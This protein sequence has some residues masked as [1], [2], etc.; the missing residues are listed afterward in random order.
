MCTL[1]VKFDVMYFKNDVAFINQEVRRQL[2]IRFAKQNATKYQGARL[3]V[4]ENC[5]T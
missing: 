1:N 2:L 4:F 3:V 5:V